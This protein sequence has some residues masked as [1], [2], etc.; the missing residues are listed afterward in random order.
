MTLNPQEKKGKFSEVFGARSSNSVSSATLSVPERLKRE[1]DMQYPVLDIDSSPLEWW[2]L[3]CKR[4]PLLAIVAQKYLGICATSGPSEHMFSIGDHLV[5]QKRNS[6]KPDKVNNMI[7]W[8][9]T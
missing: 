1:V 6:L 8:P 5:R 7:F 4:M 3:G 2:R 9:K